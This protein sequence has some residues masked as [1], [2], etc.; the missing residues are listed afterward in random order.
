MYLDQTEEK[1]P[2]LFDDNRIGMLISGP[3]SLYDMADH[4]INYGVAYLPGF[5]GDHETISG[6]DVWV[7]FN[8]SDANRAGASRVFLRW[9]TS[10]E[11]DL[12]WNLPNGNLP[13]RSSEQSTPEFAQYVTDYPGAQK[14]FDNLQNAKQA[15]PTVE[16]YPEMSHY[17]GQA[18]SAVMQGTM[19]PKEALDKAAEQAAVALR[20]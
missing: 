20:G 19:T 18:I 2:E 7:L 1:Y 3:W 11:T 4:K 9:L 5:N 14:F 13:L 8:H 10:K 15:R 6:P 16:A 12:K 17:V